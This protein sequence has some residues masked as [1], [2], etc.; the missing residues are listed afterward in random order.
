MISFSWFSGSRESGV[1]YM[2]L[3]CWQNCWLAQYLVNFTVTKV[4][5]PSDRVKIALEASRAAGI[6]PHICAQW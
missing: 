3:L 2:G 4:T 1:K 5:A 6:A